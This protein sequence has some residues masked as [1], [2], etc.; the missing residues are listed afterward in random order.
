VLAGCVDGHQEQHGR[1]TGSHN[2]GEHPAGGGRAE[3]I[4]EW[5]DESNI[6]QCMP[7]RQSHHM[8]WDY[9]WCTMQ[10]AKSNLLSHICRCVSAAKG[11]AGAAALTIL[12]TSWRTA[13][14]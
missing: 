5:W 6:T 14:S 2:D 4:I 9:H 7:W 11:L 1:D 10:A 13:S 3:S 12:Q 8:V